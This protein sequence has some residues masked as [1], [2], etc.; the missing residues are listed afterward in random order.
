LLSKRGKNLRMSR[1]DA[2]PAF[3]QVFQKCE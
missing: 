3:A 1:I 2:S